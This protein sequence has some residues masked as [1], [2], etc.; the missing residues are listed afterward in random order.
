MNGRRLV[1][2]PWEFEV[3]EIS[4]QSLTNFNLTSPGRSLQLRSLAQDTLATTTEL[5]TSGRLNGSRNGQSYKTKTRLQDECDYRSEVDGMNS[6]SN[7]R[8][9]LNCEDVKQY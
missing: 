6:N 9:Q 2:G 1:D 5:S 4:R 3:S 8:R 7:Q